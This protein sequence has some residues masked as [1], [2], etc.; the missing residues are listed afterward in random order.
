MAN[1]QSISDVN[2]VLTLAITS[3]GKVSATPVA[4]DA[5]KYIYTVTAT[6][7]VNYE[8]TVTQDVTITVELAF[9]YT[10]AITAAVGIYYFEH[11]A[12]PEAFSSIFQSIWWA[13]VTLTTVGYGDVYPVTTGGKIFTFMVLV[14]GLGIIAVPT[15]LISS[16]LSAARA[17]EKKDGNEGEAEGE[18]AVRTDISIPR[19]Y[20]KHKPL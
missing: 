3:D 8:G 16:A 2:N 12:Q 9:S 11:A 5:G 18:G 1:L 4:P 6:G 14:L 10:A 13:L 15:G 20:G 17:L 7:M 19:W